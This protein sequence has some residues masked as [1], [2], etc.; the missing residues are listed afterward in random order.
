MSEFFVL[1]IQKSVVI[2]VELV[3]KLWQF[4]QYI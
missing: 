3:T 4:S 1:E 2:K